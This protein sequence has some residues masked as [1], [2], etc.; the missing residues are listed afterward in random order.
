MKRVPRHAA[1][2]L[3]DPLGEPVLVV[4]SGERFWLETPDAHRGTVVDSTVVYASLDDV[5]ERLGG[6]NPLVGPVAVDGAAAGDCL[7]VSIEEIVPAPRRRAGYTCTT[8]AVDPALEP[9]SVI[10]PIDA[11]D[12]LLPT[13]LGDVRLPLRPMLGTLAVAPAD[14]P[15]PSF[16]QGRDVLG[17]VDLPE[18][19][20]GATVVL[21]A[22][23]DG[24]LLYGGDAHLAQG[25]A[26]IHRAAI[27]TEADVLL[28]VEVRDAESAGFAGLP[29]V[30]TPAE[31]GSVATGPGHLEDLV[32]DAYADLARRLVGAGLGRADAW[33][34][35]GAAGRVTV[36]Q[37]VPPL[38]SVLV[39]MPTAAIP[40]SPVA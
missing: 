20:Q 6:A 14:G 34:L 2:Y 1:T 16:G 15:R 9:E 26:E 19:A 33:R 13:S 31:W 29:Q 28:R 32:R 4:E 18:L 37:L 35:L 3:L 5:I 22:Q 39:R 11:G 24:G 7:L 10:C 30:N 38:S 21:R 17:N 23:V 25:E 8:P 12:V 27:E 40:V 36:G